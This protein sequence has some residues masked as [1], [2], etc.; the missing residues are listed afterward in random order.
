M[1]NEISENA[2][3]AFAT[4]APRGNVEKPRIKLKSMITAGFNF[5]IITAPL[6]DN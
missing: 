4:E 5:L 1:L 3:A 2:V 6:P